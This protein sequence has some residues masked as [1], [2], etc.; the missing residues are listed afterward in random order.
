MVNELVGL[1]KQILRAAYRFPSIK[2]NKIVA[3]IRSE[4]REGKALTDHAEITRRRTLAS[5]GLR[6][7]EDYVGIDKSSPDWQVSLRGGSPPNTLKK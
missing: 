2:R 5:D 6:Q 4:F 3:D 7:L 1:Y